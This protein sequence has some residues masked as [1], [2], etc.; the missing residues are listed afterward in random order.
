MK[1][2]GRNV[3]AVLLGDRPVARVLLGDR[4]VWAAGDEPGPDG[5]WTDFSDQTDG[6]PVTGW[7]NVAGSTYASASGT[8][9]AVE[10]PTALGG[11][12]ARVQRSADGFQAVGLDAI[13]ARSDDETTEVLAKLRL[14]D[15]S[16]FAGG[17][18]L[19]WSD[20]GST[21][22]GMMLFVTNGSI[23]RLRRVSGGGFANRADGS[24][25]WA[26]N[27]WYWVRAR[28]TGANYKVRAWEDGDA[29]PATWLI[30]HDDGTA[31]AANVGVFGLGLFR[32]TSA[33]ACDYFAWGLDGESAP[34]P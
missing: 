26:A 28:K 19:G 5:N 4:L 13:G 20:S 22:A 7:T 34:L 15:T 31:L 18:A 12:I 10:E 16:S 27:T 32:Y 6:Q 9:T 30:D 17:L 3:K 25:T 29:E 14:S 24:F 8:L 21:G 23:L 33:L 2:G 11:M 1:L